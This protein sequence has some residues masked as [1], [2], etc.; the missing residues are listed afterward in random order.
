MKTITEK[1]E[2]RSTAL[3]IVIMM[4]ILGSCSEDPSRRI[5]E[6]YQF[7]FNNS[8]ESRLLAGESLDVSAW[9]QVYTNT[10]AKVDSVR[11]I[12]E[13]V[14]GGG[15]VSQERDY[16]SSGQNIGAVWT[17][18]HDSFRQVLRA[19][20]RDLSGSLMTST[21]L[22]AYGFR[23]DEWDGVTGTPEV[24]MMDMVA[25]TVNRV[26]FITTGSYLYRQGERYYQWERVNDPIFNS[27][28]RPRT[29]EIDRNGVI[30]VSTN[31]G[32]IIRSLD[33]HGSIAPN[34]GPSAHTT[35]RYTS[36]TTTGC[37]YIRQRN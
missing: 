27:P 8:Q 31:N 7:Y 35:S 23:E 14:Q 11:V 16:V 33:R 6:N 1:W 18:G 17:L 36:P 30:F 13:P 32:N 22:V 26:T 3:M 37:G 21:D 10:F 12:F 25:D 28:D 19:S 9:F 20:V 4:V 24:Q 15:S 29:V 34:R 2:K 5:L